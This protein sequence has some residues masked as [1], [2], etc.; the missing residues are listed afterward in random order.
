MGRREF[1]GERAGRGR[2]KIRA[3]GS[4]AARWGS[5][6]ARV[7]RGR[8]KI[9]AVDDGSSALRPEDLLRRGGAAPAQAWDEVPLPEAEGTA[10]ARVTSGARARVRARPSEP[11]CAPGSAGR[12]P[13]APPATRAA[14][15]RSLMLRMPSGARRL[16]AGAISGGV[17]KTATS[18]IEVVRMR[19]MVGQG[20]LGFL[21]IA[22]EIWAAGRVKGF[23]AGNFAD[24][25]RVAPQK[26]V[27]LAA[28]DSF[29]RLLGKNDPQTGAV[30]TPPAAV[31][32]AGALAGIMSTMACYPLETVRTRMGVEPGVYKG[33]INCAQQ[34]V[35][36]GGLPVLYGGIGASLTGV[37]PYA[38][39]NLG[40]YDTMQRGYRLY[41]G[42]DK[43]PKEICGLFGA[44]A[45]PVAATMTFPLEVVRR[46]MMMGAAYSN[47]VEALRVIWTTE[48]VRALF[49]GCGLSWVKLAPSAGITFMVYELVKDELQ[50]A[51]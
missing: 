14:P 23:F 7:P 5:A 4:A 29:K 46:R 39:L 19:I 35:R 22:R 1:E 9:R 31:F 44:V 26:A 41:T 37:I 24:V 6:A 12:A 15:L 25:V 36:K 45:G 3:G 48:G 42:N 11:P 21:Q 8:R 10:G 43:V 13:R 50:V 33:I 18:P 32:C 38:A 51:R 17:G 2:G 27:Q 47:V 20:N 34:L 28:F 49:R 40:T 16:L 30:V